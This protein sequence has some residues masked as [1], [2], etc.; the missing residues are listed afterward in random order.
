[1]SDSHIGLHS[2]YLDT[3]SMAGLKVFVLIFHI[4]AMQE[5]L[6]IRNE[7]ASS[8]TQ[9]LKQRIQELENLQ[10]LEQSDTMKTISSQRAKMSTILREKVAFRP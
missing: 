9:D 7:G 2:I 6:Q 3:A 1:M 8:E 10:I 4:L 5:K